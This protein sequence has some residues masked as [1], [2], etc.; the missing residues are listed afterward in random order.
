MIEWIMKKILCFTWVWT[1]ALFGIESATTHK[2]ICLNMVVKNESD[3]I[4]K[5]LN[6]VK[7][8]I[9]YWV[10]FDLGS[11]DGTQKIV[12][13][14]LQQIPGELHEVADMNLTFYRNKAL[15]LSRVKTNYTLVMEPYEIW[16][17]SNNFTLP[18]LNKDC[19]FTKLRQWGEDQANAQRI[20]LIRNQL[21]WEWTGV[22]YDMLISTQQTDSELIGELTNACNIEVVFRFDNLTCLK[23][24]VQKNPNDARSIYYLALEYLSLEQF[25]DACDWFTKRVSMK[26]QNTEET[27]MAWMHLARA[28]MNLGE[29]A[30]ALQSYFQAHSSFPARVDPLFYIAQ[31]YREQG[32]VF[33]GYLVSNYALSLLQ[34]QD[35]HAETEIENHTLLIEF[36]N[37][38]LLYGKYQEGFNACSQLLANP[39]LPEQYKSRV[40]KNREFA[41]SRL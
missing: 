25:Q 28:Q 7:G 13:E 2:T 16:D 18:R 21:D 10:I 40:S 9:D 5:C 17:F 27:L 37:N 6:S 33:L 1:A 20:A 35:S 29:K 15:S 14:C 38:A 30:L 24:E 26:S 31:I 34:V 22:S 4:E 8:F 23:K 39:K 41:K 36:A 19:Y 12:C 3:V 32:N 11:T